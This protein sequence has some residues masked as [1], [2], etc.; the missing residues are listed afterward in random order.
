MLLIYIT[1]Y[2][3]MGQVKEVS[4]TRI[5]RQPIFETGARLQATG[6]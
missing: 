4:W 2:I 1:L 3:L 5:Q 6:Y